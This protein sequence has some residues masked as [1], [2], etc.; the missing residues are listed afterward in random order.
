[1][2]GKNSWGEGVRYSDI[3]F[4]RCDAKASLGFQISDRRPFLSFEN[5][6]GAKDFGKAFLGV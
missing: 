3:S 2:G 4:G 6:S 1:M 5:F